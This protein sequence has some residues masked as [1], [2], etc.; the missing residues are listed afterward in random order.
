MFVSTLETTNKIF[1]LFIN[2]KKCFLLFIFHNQYFQVLGEKKIFLSNNCTF[3]HC[4]SNEPAG[5][6]QKQRLHFQKN[7]YFYN[8]PKMVIHL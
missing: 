4:I 1:D 7:Q 5:L 8:F 6:P 3:E 2:K